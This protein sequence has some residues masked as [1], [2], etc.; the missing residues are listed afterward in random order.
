MTRYHVYAS[1]DD[2][3]REG[4]TYVFMQTI[5]GK[6]AILATM[7]FALV[8]LCQ[9]KAVQIVPEDVSE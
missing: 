4:G 1:F 7:G 2:D 8:Q 5:E 3:P 6:H 9:G